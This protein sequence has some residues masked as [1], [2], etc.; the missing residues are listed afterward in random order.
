MKPV[1][2]LAYTVDLVVGKDAD[3]GIAERSPPSL[4]RAAYRA[5]NSDLP[6][7]LKV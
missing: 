2:G 4:V 6:Q 3:D 1:A 5:P 7:P